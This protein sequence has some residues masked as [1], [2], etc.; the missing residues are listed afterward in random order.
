MTTST[1]GLDIGSTA[2][3]AVRLRT[4]PTGRVTV[5]FLSQEIL[6]DQGKDEVSQSQLLR[7]FIKKHRLIGSRLVTALPCSDLMMRTISLP[8]HDTRKL[9]QVIPSEVESMIP[10][11]LEEV[12][13]DYELLTQRK[14]DQTMAPASHSQILVAA[15]Q[16]DT[17]LEHVQFLAEIGIEP[18]AVR[19]DAL[20]LF[21]FFNR[22]NQRQAEPLKQVALID[23]GAKR[24][25]LCLSYKGD[26]WILR[27]IRYGTTHLNRLNQGIERTGISVAADT[28]IPKR[29]L[30]IEQMEPGFS[31]LVRE[32]RSTLHA[33]EAST[34]H[35]LKQVWFTG[36]GAESGELT[37][38][39]ARSLELDPISL[40]ESFPVPCA[41]AY[42]VAMGLALMGTPGRMPQSLSRNS[43]GLAINLKRVMNT[44][45]ARSQERR[46]HLIRAVGVSLLILL[47][48]IAD[49]S[50]QV[51]LKQSR[52]QELK[53][54]A[55]SQFQQQFS[56]IE[57]VTDELDQ[58]KATVQTA[59]K[60]VDL[61]SGQQVAM[62]PV[63][64]DLVRQFPKGN[65]VKIKGLQIERAAIQIEAES[66]S[67]EA[68]ERIRQGLL[69]FPEARE[70]T[71]RDARVGA[72]P[73]QVLFRIILARGPA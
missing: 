10:F 34:H 32:I 47:F 55:R 17:V 54:Q 31:G 21:S 65:S 49:L 8:F 48:A 4:A 63:L 51:M 37:V 59:R 36:G 9:M 19:V 26:P 66:D 30:T 24:T 61:L 73:N 53:A 41:P 46:K 71:I 6:L 60:T 15:A 57:V 12:A 27:S 11:P 58:A 28:G 13:L 25:T 52:L 1:V 68:M 29:P 35:R 69:G 72:T 23:L 38:L 40:P 16:R 67:F 22:L 45:V 62:L 14:S 50:V 56:G 20:A 44:T 64:A 43:S 70:V 7:Q 3:K 33:Y 39:L 5:D 2:V 18:A 42:A